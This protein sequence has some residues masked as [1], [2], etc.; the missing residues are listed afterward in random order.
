M[1]T[2]A[3]SPLSPEPSPQQPDAIAD[4]NQHEHIAPTLELEAQ[5]LIDQAGSPDLAK[6]AI[7]AA[8]QHQAGAA[9]A[10]ETSAQ[11]WGFASRVELLAASAPY[12]GPDGDSWW[13]TAIGENSWMIWNERNE[14]PPRQFASVE[15]AQQFLAEATKD[16]APIELT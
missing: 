4:W 10:P 2:T 14:T 5:K 11:A 15:A 8:C 9:G 12:A 16:P 3:S 6:Q 1:M 7:D 13:I